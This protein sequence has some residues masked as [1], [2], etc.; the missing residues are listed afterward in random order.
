MIHSTPPP[1]HSSFMI[2]IKIFLTKKNLQLKKLAFFFQQTMT[3]FTIQRTYS[4]MQVTFILI[5]NLIGF[6]K[7]FNLKLI[8]IYHLL[9]AYSCVDRPN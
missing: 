4:T 7:N 5:L 1:L 9:N 8:K 2:F 3:V 6:E